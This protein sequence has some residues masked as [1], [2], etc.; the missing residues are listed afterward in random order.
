MTADAPRTVRYVVLHHTGFGEPHFDLLIDAE[1]AGPLLSW[2]L[3]RWPLVGG[4]AVPAAVHRREYLDYEGPVSRGR[5]AVM[6]A[7]VGTVEIV[8]RDQE[9]ICARFP[10]TGCTVELNLR[11]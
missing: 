7:A 9:T 2:R 5:G 11:S 1:G 4:D 6:Q 10:G 8:S 3:S